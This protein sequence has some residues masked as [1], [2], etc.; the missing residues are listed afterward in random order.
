MTQNLILDISSQ[1]F[2]SAMGHSTVSEIEQYRP[3]GESLFS[4]KATKTVWYSRFPDMLCVQLQRVAHESGHLVKLN[5]KF[6]FEREIYLDRYLEA[7]KEDVLQRRAK[8]SSL[9]AERQKLENDLKAYTNYKGL[10]VALDVALK[11]VQSCFE[12]DSLDFVEVHSTDLKTSSSSEPSVQPESP[13]SSAISSDVLAKVL[14]R[15]H[16][17]VTSRIAM[18]RSQL[19]KLRE[20]E[21]RVFEDMKGEKFV[22]HAA[23]VHDGSTAGQGHYW[24]FVR[25]HHDGAWIKYDDTRVDEVSEEEVWLMSQG[26][27]KN[28][29]AYFLVFVRASTLPEPM[30]IDQM[31][32]FV[33]SLIPPDIHKEAVLDQESFQKELDTWTENE[34]QKKLKELVGSFATKMSDGFVA[35]RTAFQTEGYVDVSYP[36]NLEQ[37]LVKIKNDNLL[38]VTLFRRLWPLFVKDCQTWIGGPSQES[39]SSSQPGPDSSVPPSDEGPSPTF[40]EQE[41]LVA[42][43]DALHEEADFRYMAM[44]IPPSEE[45]LADVERV[46]LDMKQY[47]EMTEIHCRALE[48]WKTY[49][50]VKALKLLVQAKN[51]SSK[52]SSTEVLSDDLIPIHMKAI[53]QLIYYKE[54]MLLPHSGE[55]SDGMK[56]AFSWQELRAMAETVRDHFNPS[57]EIKKFIIDFLMKIPEEITEREDIIRIIFEDP[58]NS[59]ATNN[60]SDW[61]KQDEWDSKPDESDIMAHGA[62]ESK[63]DM[64]EAIEI[65][66][67]VNSESS[68]QISTVLQEITPEITSPS[69][70]EINAGGQKIVQQTSSD[71]AQQIV[72]AGQEITQISSIGQ[73]TVQSSTGVVQGTGVN[74]SVQETSLIG[75]EMT[76]ISTDVD[77]KVDVGVS[78][79][80]TNSESSRQIRTIG[81]EMPQSSTDV[82]QQAGVNRSQEIS[83]E[84]PQQIRPIGQEMTQNSTDVPQQAGVNSSQEI[85]SEPPQQ[86]RPIGQEMTQNSTDVPQQ[87]GVNSSQEISSEPP[88]QIRPIGQEMTQSSTDVPQHAGVHGSVESKSEHLEGEKKSENMDSDA[89]ETD[90]DEDWS[91]PR[92][93][94]IF[95]TFRTLAKWVRQRD[96]KFFDYV[97]EMERRDPHDGDY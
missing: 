23:L 32:S 31:D 2:H 18:L 64:G 22:L 61:D 47:W 79:E 8:L 42:A 1:D 24:A 55:I 93:E 10:D 3:S 17:A 56:P 59:D 94:H 83:S 48:A 36:K 96:G 38:L 20:D 92:L 91:E 39:R 13:P 37:F 50:N 73:D 40:S 35:A 29:S 44:R 4:T 54:E 45:T 28:A 74:D 5:T 33:K 19:D 88:Q 9:E 7:H 89:T 60:S 15:K 43:V 41:L 95:R 72:S 75:Q 66:Q 68:Q 63:S 62:V 11:A 71:H 65:V 53:V 52:I 16:S 67:I 97:M 84:P 58:K 6:K 69:S 78:Q 70:Q 51:L 21:A 27:E 12:D 81:Q 57:C 26:G 77:Q 30:S 14:A 34:K 87:A 80:T 46:E 25:R 86:I 90:E 85:S 49:E 76:N 82:P